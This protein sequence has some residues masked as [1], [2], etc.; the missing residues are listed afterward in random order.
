MTHLDGEK[1]YT[2]NTSQLTAHRI[3]SILVVLALLVAVVPTVIAAAPPQQAPIIYYVRYG[4]T[5]F[6]ISQRFGTTV[7]ALMSANGLTSYYIYAGQRLVIPTGVPP[8]PPGPIYG[9]KYTV[10]YRDTIYSIAYRYGVPWYQLMQANYLY[11]PYIYVGQQLNVPCLNPPPTP[12]PTYTVQQGDNLFRIAIKYSTSIY[13]IALVNGIY[14]P[15]WI[16]F[17][18]T[19]VIPYPGSVKWPPVPTITPSAVAPTSA[20]I[21]TLTF[22]P[23]ATVTGTVAATVTPSPTGS[24]GTQGV[25]IMQ[26]VTFLPQQVTIT[27]GG[28]VLWKNQDSITHTVTSGVPGTIDN[29]FRSGPIGPGQTYTFQFNDAGPYPYFS[30]LDPGMTGTVT[31]Q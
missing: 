11:S 1:E 14:N 20:P 18:Q 10:Q 22:T 24:G 26:N 29:K 31:V 12:F 23:S 6:S 25:V 8:V 17:G 3:L 2:M 15:N 7:P 21:P 9:C 28:S 13:A 27:R 5:L 16:F 19:L 4:D 30:E